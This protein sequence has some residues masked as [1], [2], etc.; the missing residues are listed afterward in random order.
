[1][2]ILVDHAC[3]SS[4]GVVSRLGGPGSLMEDSSNFSQGQEATLFGKA[5]A[6]LDTRAS[7]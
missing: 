7:S 6:E 4:E 1:M 2:L 3:H 5:M